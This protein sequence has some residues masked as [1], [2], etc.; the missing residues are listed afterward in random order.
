MVVW[1]DP[2][3]IRSLGVTGALPSIPTQPNPN[4]TQANP[5][6]NQSQPNPIKPF[7][8]LHSLAQSIPAQP[9]STQPLPNLNPYQNM[10][11]GGGYVWW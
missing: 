10:D 6:P 4:P 11:W 7:P 1:D 2:G 5:T 8:A 9:N 3:A